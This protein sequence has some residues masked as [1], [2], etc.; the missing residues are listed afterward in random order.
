VPSAAAAAPRPGVD[1][2]SLS[3]LYVDYG[4]GSDGAAGT[5]SSAPLRTIA[6]AVA[7]STS[8]AAPVTIFLVGTATHYVEDTIKLTAAHS[9]LTITGSNTDAVVS[10]G[11]AFAGAWA[12]AGNT[13]G[14]TA[15]DALFVKFCL[16]IPS[17][18]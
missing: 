3:D 1:A 5:S 16:Y 13:S 2:A 18:F 17:F 4:A 11:V 8:M 14:N 6:A 15:R 9:G 7:K 12:V 10:G